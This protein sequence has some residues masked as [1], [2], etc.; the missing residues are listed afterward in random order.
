MSIAPSKY[1]LTVAFERNCARAGYEAMKEGGPSLELRSKFVEGN[2]V[3]AKAQDVLFFDGDTIPYSKKIQISLNATSA[4]FKDTGVTRI[5]QPTLK[6]PRD[7]IIRLDSLERTETGWNNDEVKSGL[8][9]K[10]K[11][12]FDAL[13]STDRAT[14]AGVNIEETRIIHINKEWRLGDSEDELFNIQ[15]ITESIVDPVMIQFLEET[16]AILLEGF[17]PPAELVRGCWGCPL[18]PKCF[19]NPINPITV[20]KRMKPEGIAKLREQGIVDVS[21]IP[22]DFKLTPKQSEHVELIQGGCPVVNEDGLKA[23]L[24]KLEEP[25][26]HLDFESIAFAIPL[27]SD[28]APWGQVAS[29]YSIHIE[30]STGLEHREFLCEAEGDQRRV[31]AEM[32]IEDIGYSGSIM[33][34]NASFERKRIEEMAELFSDL[35]PQLEAIVPRLVDL[36]PIVRKNVLHPD[37]KGSYSLKSVFPVLVPGLG[38]SDLDISGGGEAQG[39]MNLMV[40]NQIDTE[41][42]PLLRERLLRYCERDTEATAGILQALREMVNP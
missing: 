34:W 15:D 16:S 14:R 7:E 39:A 8:S 10:D 29:Q 18:F 5:N 27:H 41:E 4:Q 33:V 28:V 6:T 37:F 25:I 12:R 9:V 32:L 1:A 13:I 26:H 19:Q 24:A 11:Y 40:R 30:T 17:R 36:W 21:D 20:L 23:E 35:A 3:D 38:Y 22:D 42:I 2:V 31:L